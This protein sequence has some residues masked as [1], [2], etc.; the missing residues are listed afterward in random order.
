MRHNQ[1]K[2][3]ILPLILLFTIF[4]FVSQLW[5]QEQTE[6]MNDILKKELGIEKEQKETPAKT[7][8]PE[9]KSPSD[10]SNTPANPKKNPIEEKIRANQ[11]GG[12]SLIWVLLKIIIVFGI[13]LGAMYYILRFISQ[14]R[15]AKYPVQGSMRVLANLGL[16]T[17]KEL[18]IV[19]VE[20]D[21]LLLGVSDSS[22]NLIKEITASETKEK[23][24]LKRDEHEPVAVNFLESLVTNIK[25]NAAFSQGSKPNQAER[26]KPETQKNSESEF[27]EDMMNE[28]KLRQMERLEKMKQERSNL[29]G[30]TK[31]PRTAS[32]KK[33]QDG[34]VS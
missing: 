4:S 5:G 31:K 9:K 7:P 26:S 15:N 34:E 27:Q 19:E 11:D 18:Q 1:L 14:N 8:K 3:G 33:S 21:L 32:R 16:G 17:N 2:K 24:L 22:I 29:S 20:G 10:T 23:I 12:S 25:Q 28:I 6:E 13:L 30:S